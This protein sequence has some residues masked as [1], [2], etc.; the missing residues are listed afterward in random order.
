M[1]VLSINVWGVLWFKNASALGGAQNIALQ[2]CDDTQVVVHSVTKKNGRMWGCCTPEKLAELIAAN[3]GIYEVLSEFPQKVYFDLDKAG[4]HPE[5]LDCATS[6]IQKMLPGAELAVSGSVTDEKTSYH[7]VVQNYQ[8]NSENDRKAMRVLA[9]RLDGFDAAVYTKNR[10][11]K[12]PNQS[13]LDGRVQAVM[14]V[15]DLRR[16]LI[17]CF[18][19]EMQPL[20]IPDDIHLE[21]E[22]RAPFD[23]STLPKTV[24]TDVL[25]LDTMT[26]VQ[27][28]HALPVTPAWQ[29]KDSA[30]V[31]RFAFH[32]KIPF[33]E[34]LTWAHLKH[35]DDAKWT[36]QWGRAHLFPEVTMESMRLQ[37]KHFYPNS[38]RVKDRHLNAFK[39]TFALPPTE[40]V[41]TLSPECFAGPE[42]F[43]CLNVGMG[44]G[45][46]AQTCDYLEGREFV[47]IAPII[48]LARNLM[49]RVNAAFYSDKTIDA[50]NEPRLLVVMNSLHKV[51][52][53]FE[54]VVIDESETVLLK[55]MGDFMNQTVKS[56]KKENWMVFLQLIRAAKRVILLDA[57]TSTKTLDLMRRICPGEV[58]IVE[59]AEEPKTRQV[60]YVKS[61]E[62]MITQMQADLAADKKVFCYYPQKH[63]TK[64]SI[65][66]E[67][68]HDVLASSGKKG[69][70]Y[71]SEIDERIKGG[72]RDVNAAWA[73]LDFVITNNTITCGVNYDLHT[74]PFDT[75]YIF[76]ASY[77][78]PRDALQVSYRPRLLTE[79]TIFVNF[80]GKMSQR[81]V[82]EDDSGFCPIY[83]SLYEAN[84]VELQAPNR[85]TFGFLCGKAHYTQTTD[86]TEFCEEQAEKLRAVLDEHATGYS[87]I[88]LA[89]ISEKEADDIK[90]RMFNGT[91]TMIEKYTYTRF[92]FKLQFRLTPAVEA[93]VEE[94]WDA[95]WIRLTTQIREPSLFD[96]I[97]ALNSFEGFPSDLTKVKLSE[98]LLDEIFDK[99][100]FKFIN[101]SSPTVSILHHIYNDF[102]GVI[103]TAGYESVKN[104]TYNLVDG[105]AE[106]FSFVKRETCRKP[107][108]CATFEMGKYGLCA[109]GGFK[110]ARACIC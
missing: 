55:F 97:A 7:V 74:K 71:N 61:K 34:F 98:A 25:D 28:M 1:S 45:K 65:S 33:G 29:F 14:T 38:T 26:P 104:A 32:N 75:A 66:M 70:Y 80:M 96:R 57:F 72:L 102:Y 39:Q 2:Y 11:M 9:G 20:P 62:Q 100:K 47:W 51:R 107:C 56:R 64:S 68:L 84:L 19:T 105:V 46:T 53:N 79:N 8:L 43:L 58:R 15:P 76:I 78:L 93:K 40:K 10:N 82:W 69:I 88:G 108:R 60:V 50:Y 22:A 90:D 83:R 21:T 95:Q 18:Q 103:Y 48:A 59:R 23:M 49:S 85:K 36:Y 87:Y 67:G 37:L 106:Y 86:D 73:D 6:E 5:Y 41:V 24:L 94:A 12:C 44:G 91:A 54:T 89:D 63:Q 101:R 31:L 16:H 92:H 77:T 13:K 42:K 52:Q 109:C 17:T 81:E 99:F 27:M 4:R 3:H 35:D 110:V 30:R